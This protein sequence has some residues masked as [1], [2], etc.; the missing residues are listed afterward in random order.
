MNKEIMEE[1]NRVNVKAFNMLQ[2]EY[3]IN[4][5]AQTVI[6]MD[7]N[8]SLLFMDWAFWLYK[9]VIEDVSAI[10]CLVSSCVDYNGMTLR[11]VLGIE[12]SLIE[13]YSDLLCFA[14]YGQTYENYLIF[15]TQIANTEYKCERDK[16]LK[17]FTPVLTNIFNV[18]I[19]NRKTRYYLLG[20]ANNRLR[21]FSPD[22]VKFNEMLTIYDRELSKV[23]HNNLN[24]NQ[25]SNE[26]IVMEVFYNISCIM[27][28]ATYAIQAYENFPNDMRIDSLVHSCVMLRKLT[29]E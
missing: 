22:I 29:S 1:M 2:L 28:A 15:L 3:D 13:K 5:K 8:S 25:K 26:D 4:G 17:N 18:D 6:N 27:Q 23:L 9:G 12:R 11:P 21:T 7:G 19:V 24:R 10:A 16:V 14:T 20:E